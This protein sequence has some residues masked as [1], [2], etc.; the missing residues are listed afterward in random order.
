MCR[1]C[2]FLFLSLEATR[3]SSVLP[4]TEKKFATQEH[5]QNYEDDFLETCVNHGCTGF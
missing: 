5:G 1:K 2:D 3:R 4:V